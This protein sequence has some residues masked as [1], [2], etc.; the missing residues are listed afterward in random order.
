MAYRAHFCPSLR[1][2][3]IRVIFVI[4]IRENF[5]ILFAAHCCVMNLN[6]LSTLTSILRLFLFSL[7]SSCCRR[8][9]GHLLKGLHT[10]MRS[11]MQ[12]LGRFPCLGFPLFVSGSVLTPPHTGLRRVPDPD[13]GAGLGSG[14]R[15]DADHRLRH[16]LRAVPACVPKSCP[17]CSF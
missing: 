16:P 9:F 8:H 12:V 11:R 14:G 3:H 5:V 17:L 7:V 2:L 13:D 10:P 1:Y 15:R 4:I 6:G